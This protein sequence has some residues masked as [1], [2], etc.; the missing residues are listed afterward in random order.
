MISNEETKQNYEVVFTPRALD[1]LKR[2]TSKPQK[3]M[4][5]IIEKKCE[6]DPIVDTKVITADD[7][8]MFT[9]TIKAYRSNYGTKSKYIYFY[10]WCDKPYDGDLFNDHPFR[11]IGND[12][13]VINNN[14]CVHQIV[15]DNKLSRLILK[16]L[17]MSDTELSQLSGHQ[18]VVGYRSTL[19]KLLTEL[20]D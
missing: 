10:I 16:M 9:L 19:I 4:E 11:L 2:I 12:Y 6:P 5:Q 17:C 8:E 18:T 3:T 13:N 7:N 15:V 20:W 14:K 1:D